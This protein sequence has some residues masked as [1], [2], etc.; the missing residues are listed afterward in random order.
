MSFM[1]DTQWSHEDFVQL[2]ES[3]CIWC[4]CSQVIGS[5]HVV[6]HVESGIRF[7]VGTTCIE[8]YSAARLKSA[9]RSALA[10]HRRACC[11]AQGCTTKIDR[12]TKLG[13]RGVCSPLCE[14]Q[15]VACE[16]ETWR[17][18]AGCA[19]TLNPAD[20]PAWKTHCIGCYRDLPELANLRVPFREKDDAKALGARWAP[21]S[22]VWVVP[23]TLGD[24]A[25]QQLLAR[26]G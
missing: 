7:K 15:L 21:Q 1:P 17:R 23:P 9:A 2:P 18:C 19:D 6:R 4:I 14:R 13:R 8:R 10:L 3:D 20:Y 5:Y 26:W 24:K 22:K 25:R 12:R 16:Q 11:Q